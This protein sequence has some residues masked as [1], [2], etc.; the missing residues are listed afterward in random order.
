M[1]QTT[2]KIQ[3]THCAS[4]AAVLTK[5]LSRTLGVKTAFVNYSTEKASVEFDPEITNEQKLVQS[6]GCAEEQDL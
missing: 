4:C 3:G 1:K 2:L 5:A 6:L